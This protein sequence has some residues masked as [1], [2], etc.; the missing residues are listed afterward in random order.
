M[1][2]FV[3]FAFCNPLSMGIFRGVIKCVFYRKIN[4]S[5]KN[6][7][8]LKDDYI[9][10]KCS[11]CGKFISYNDFINGSASMKMITPDSE[12]SI[13]EFEYLCIKCK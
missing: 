5:D 4:M 12:Y 1:A 7:E 2:I 11:S 6:I 8:D 9:R 10:F 3:I 13:E